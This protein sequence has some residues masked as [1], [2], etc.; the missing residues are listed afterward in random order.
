MT[1]VRD[2]DVLG[3][4]CDEIAPGVYAF[5][6]GAT[7]PNATIVHGGGEVMLIDALMTLRQSARLKTAIDGITSD[8][9]TRL[10]Y[11]HRHGD[12]VLGAET[13]ASSLHTVAG[14]PA[15][16]E[17]LRTMGEDYI[18]LYASW[19]RNEQ[20]EADV[21]AISQV[22]VPNLSI[23]TEA[24]L[25]VG[26]TEV[27][28][29]RQQLAHSPS[30]LLALLPEHGVV[31][32]GDIWSPR[33]VPGMRDGRTEGWIQRLEEIYD[34]HPEVIV[35]GH[36]PWTK[37]R[38]FVRELR[39]FLAVAWEATQAGVAAG[40]DVAA[41]VAGIDIDAWSHFYGLDRYPEVIARMYDERLER[42]S[43]YDEALTEKKRALA[44]SA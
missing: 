27:R 13:F 3:A 29:V 5:M 39:D 24:S 28:L 41:I 19:R 17:F 16:T 43:K 32:T 14:T 12:H 1:V 6:T 31:C 9:V 37:D 4:G 34:L 20:D 33:I 25:F 30:D 8:P 11:T 40:K 10:A 18:P 7:G 42:P 15:T 23:E 35:P 21:R 38:Y 44:P 2:L 22:V 26:D 36:G